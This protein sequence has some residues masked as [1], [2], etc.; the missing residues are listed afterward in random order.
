MNK[1]EGDFQLFSIQQKGPDCFLKCKKSRHYLTV[2]GPFTGAR[3]YGT[4]KNM[5]Q[6]QRF[7]LK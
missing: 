1:T 3:V 2:E 5:G 4:S 7:R 6:N